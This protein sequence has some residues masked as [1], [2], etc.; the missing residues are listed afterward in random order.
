MVEHKISVC[1]H[2]CPD[3]CGVK[4]GVEND[5]IVSIT[6]DPDH[7]I[8]R[9]FLCGKVNRYAE[10]VYAPERILHPMRRV[11]RKGEGKFE[12]ITWDAALDEIAARLKSVI[13][14]YGAEAVLPYSFTGTNA[15]VQKYGGHRFFFA[16]GATQLARTLCST[17][18]AEGLRM[19]NGHDLATD[20]EEVPDSKLILLWGINAVATNIH[21]MPLVKEARKRGARVVVIDCY[22]TQTARQADQ[23]IQI[24]PGTD[25]ALAL[26][27]VHVILAAGL[28]DADFI[29]KYTVGIADL[30]AAC[31]EWTPERTQQ[32]T[33]VPAATVRD[34]A[35][36]YGRE[37][38]AFI[39][40]G[41]GLSRRSN[42]A[43]TLRTL[44][45][46]P[47]VTGAWA[48]Q[49][50]GFM[51]SSWGHRWLNLDY[52]IAPPKGSKPA[53]VVNMVQLGNALLEL[54]D[55][56]VKALFVYNANPAAVAPDQSRVHAGLARED[57][58]TVVHEQ[59]MTDTAD[60]AD[61]L[62]PATTFFEHD[63]IQTAYGHSY[64]QLSRAAIPPVG[65]AKSNFAL[66]QALAPRM[67]IT[68]PLYQMGFEEILDH[69]L[70]RDWAPTRALDKQKL[71]TGQAVKFGAWERPWESGLKTPSGKFEF[72]SAAMV[73]AG[74]PAAPAYTRPA[75]GQQDAALRQT[76][77]IAL[78]TPPSQHFLNSTFVNA[79]TSRKLE[80]QP[81]LKLSP[82]DAEARGLHTGDACRAFNQ[83]GECFLT[84][85]VTEDVA[86]GTAVAESVWWPKFHPHRKGI[87]QLTDSRLLTDLGGGAR[88]HDALVQIEGTPTR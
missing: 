72:V 66:F 86:Q 71:L 88:L 59:A 68:D 69:L 47:A 61:I 74:Q 75:G 3:S 65:E 60:F 11:G 37:R 49:G 83:R 48:V 84:V 46:L 52:L 54:S 55:P 78:L 79:P 43:M 15:T 36:A 25:A 38:A 77:P 1:P 42:G 4:V 53:R 50:G 19:T 16:L 28:H 21:F 45:C 82:G 14:E 24:R 8:T 63:D 26:G 70:D 5:R 29:A 80:R 39:R 30:R 2:N 34:L 57:L 62:L 81:T 32:V 76:Y 40:C 22:R 41:L 51:R 23:F 10:R 9:G 17:Q 7:P 87:N 67:G 44:A 31:A 56:P 20:V 27:M 6:G 33:G 58:F 13:A 12:R 64:A 35:L 73:A 18:A 85:E